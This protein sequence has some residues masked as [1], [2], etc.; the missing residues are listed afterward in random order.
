MNFSHLKSF[1]PLILV[2]DNSHKHLYFLRS[3]C[4]FVKLV[5]RLNRRVRCDVHIFKFVCNFV[6]YTV[7]ETDLIRCILVFFRRMF[8]NDF[9]ILNLFQNLLCTVDYLFRNTCKCRNFNTVTVVRSASDDFT[10]KRNI[11]TTF[12]TAIL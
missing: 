4:Q 12:F 3:V 5:H 7:T 11:V 8:Y 2:F 10:Q 1:Q 9:I 6:C